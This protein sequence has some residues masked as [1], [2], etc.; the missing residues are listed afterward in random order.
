LN[1]QQPSIPPDLAFLYQRYVELLTAVEAGHLEVNDALQTLLT[2]IAVDSTGAEW[3]I[4]AEGVFLR[5]LPGGIPTP[6]DPRQFSSIGLRASSYNNPTDLSRPPYESNP[7]SASQL[8]DLQ[9]SYSFNPPADRTNEPR[10]A[11]LSRF[12][13]VKLP[14]V[15][16]ERRRAAIVVTICALLVVLI[17]QISGGETA[18]KTTPIP[19]ISTPSTTSITDAEAAAL[20]KALSSNREQAKTALAVGSPSEL[21]SIAL[22]LAAAKALGFSIQAGTPLSS[23]ESVSIPVTIYD[24]ESVVASWYLPVSKFEGRWVATGSVTAKE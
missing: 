12:Q 13:F 14:S 15:P 3:S 17:S 16:R 4:N 19:E 20:V 2:L 10:S 21:L 7:Y 23:D 22:H 6:A 11:L 1:N 5:S 9:G 8:Q 18:V 24:G